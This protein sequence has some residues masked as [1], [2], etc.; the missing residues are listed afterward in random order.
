MKPNPMPDQLVL[1]TGKYRY[2]RNDLQETE[3]RKS[4]AGLG[5]EAIHGSEPGG[6][7][8][9]QVLEET[10]TRMHTAPVSALKMSKIFLQRNQICH[11][12]LKYQHLHSALLH[13]NPESL[14]RFIQCTAVRTL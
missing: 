5:K 8:Q 9:G 2:K 3:R 10:Q 1:Q 4:V 13:E 11:D 12:C 14:L 6:Q 7:I